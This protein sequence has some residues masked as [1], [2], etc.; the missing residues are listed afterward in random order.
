M[1]GT[2]HAKRA[3]CS[4]LFRQR[5]ILHKAMS[6]KPDPYG[7]DAPR[8]YLIPLKG[9]LQVAQRV[10][11]EAGR[12]NLSVVAAGCA[13]Y[14][15]FAVFPA[16][17]ALIALYG[18]TADPA[19]VEQQF[20]MLSFVLPPQAFQIVIDQIRRV[21]ETPN[22]S[23]S[24]GLALSIV[25]AVWSVSSLTQ[26]IFAALNIAYEEPERRSPVRFYLSAFGFALLGI[27]SGALML[28]AIVYVPILFAYAGYSHAFELIVRVV[29][30]P[31]LAA[32]V[33]FLLALLYRYGPCRRSAKWHWVS[34]GSVFATLLWLIASA[35]FSF[36]VSHIANYD[37]T[38][39]SL[40]AVI[41]LLFW[42]YITFYI[43]LLGAEINA[44]LELQTAEDTTRGG[45]RPLGK[46]GAFVADH[47]AGGPEGA[48]RPV[49]AVAAHP[50]KAKP[51][52]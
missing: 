28:L 27:L 17:S 16:L 52:S 43:V 35:G 11:T 13:F 30:W 8:P 26:A 15:L 1:F 48:K 29:R 23:L 37:R 49:S 3:F 51:Q 10:W 31:L 47:V 9:W 40:G 38:Y 44:E 22:Q 32:L 18:L 34:M 2:K 7:R 21:A 33:L 14:A 6:R 5:T 50:E 24:W 42:L 46:R 12:D 4:C 20:D 39:G 25:L 36:Y 41:V 19:S 45:P